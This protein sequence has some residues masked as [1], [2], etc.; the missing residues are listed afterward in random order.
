[1]IKSSSNNP[2]IYQIK[3]FKINDVL[4]FYLSDGKI[5]INFINESD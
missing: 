3:L 5:Y 1:M 4:I 2:I